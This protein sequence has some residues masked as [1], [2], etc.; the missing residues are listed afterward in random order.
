L[1]EIQAKHIEQVWPDAKR[2]I[3]KTFDFLENVLQ[4]KGPNLVPFRYYYLVFTTFFYKNRD[5]NYQF[6]QQYFWFY[7]FHNEDLLSNTGDLW[8]HVELVGKS[9]TVGQAYKLDPFVIDRNKLRNST[10]SSKG[11][12]A[13]AIL[14]LYANQKPRDWATPHRFVLADV[15]YILTDKPNLHHVFPLDFIENNPGANKLDSN[16]LMN[17]AYLTQI[18]N[19]QISN[20]NPVQYMKDYMTPDFSNVLGEHLV[21]VEILKWAKGD[22]LAEGALDVFIEKRIDIIVDRLKENLKG[23]DIQVIDTK[24]DDSK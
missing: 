4:L 14:S 13:R 23:V 5:P 16:S 12:L 8:R 19:L 18:T 15:Y 21:P 3:L 24:G 1:G 10:Y 17:I 11:R 6:L 7:S 22:D 20:R 9:K 2:A